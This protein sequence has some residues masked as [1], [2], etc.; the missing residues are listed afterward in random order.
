MR[1]TGVVSK[2]STQ[3]ASGLVFDLQAAQPFYQ[4]QIKV[5]CVYLTKGFDIFQ[6]VTPPSPVFQRRVC[7]AVLRQPGGVQVGDGAGL[8]LK[9]LP[10]DV[11]AGNLLTGLADGDGLAALAPDVD[12]LA[13]FLP[14]GRAL[15]A[16]RL[17]RLQLLDGRL[18]G[19]AMGLQVLHRLFAQSDDVH[20]LGLVPH[21]A[22]EHVDRLNVRALLHHA[23]QSHVSR[24]LGEE[25][26]PGV[27]RFRRLPFRGGHDADLLVL[28]WHKVYVLH[29]SRHHQLDLLLG[30]GG[31]LELL[32]LQ[33]VP[34]LLGRRRFRRVGLSS[35]CCSSFFVVRFDVRFQIVQAGERE[36]AEGAGEGLLP[37]V[38]RDMPPPRARVREGFL[39]DAA[40][41]GLL[42]S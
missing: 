23:A 20:L 38:G 2:P 37:G 39:T 9:H 22:L 24:R 19:A 35:C 40:V 36:A 13:A 8:D 12:G 28:R 41:V 16:L 10:L 26:E 15:R 29:T 7:S 17:H 42:T 31:Q 27:R 33:D 4:T 18:R 32:Q 1:F 34:H 30:A 25:G 3:S 11:V 14:A 5:G 21:L 6:K